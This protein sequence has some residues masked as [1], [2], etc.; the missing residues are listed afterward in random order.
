M[1]LRRRATNVEFLKGSIEDIPLSDGS[2]DVVISNCVI[3]LPVDKPK[4]ITEM[5]RVL[6]PGGRIGISDGGRGPPQSEGTGRTRLVRGLHRRSPISAGVPRRPHLRRLQ[7]RH[8]PFHS[9]GRGWHAQRNHPSDQAEYLSM[10]DSH[11]TAM[12]SAFLATGVR[13]PRTG[14]GWSP[15][16]ST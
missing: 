3:N 11:T 14:R 4:V 10:I 5:F 9:P 15:A 6:S 12:G 13:A 2:V 1:P 16:T 7:Q 8:C